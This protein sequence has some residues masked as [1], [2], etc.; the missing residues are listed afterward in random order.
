MARACIKCKEYVI[1]QPND[2]ENQRVIK[3]FEKQHSG[4]NLI[5]LELEEIKDSYRNIETK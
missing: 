5:T 4:H 3:Q 2:P 1:V